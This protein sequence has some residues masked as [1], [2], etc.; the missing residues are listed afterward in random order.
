[1]RKAITINLTLRLWILILAF[2]SSFF[3][4]VKAKENIL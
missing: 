1:M 4:I 2:N 3:E